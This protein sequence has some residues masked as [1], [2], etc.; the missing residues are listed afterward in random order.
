MRLL[1]RDVLIAR[2]G[3]GNRC[4]TSGR[5]LDRHHAFSR[6][7]CGKHPAVFDDF[8]RSRSGLRSRYMAAVVLDVDEAAASY[9]WGQSPSVARA[10]SKDA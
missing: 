8:D 6:V 10:R 2:V 5:A 4:R 1:V 9:R 7:G 3:D